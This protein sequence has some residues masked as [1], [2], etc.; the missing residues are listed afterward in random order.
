MNKEILAKG[1]KGFVF[2]LIP[3]VLIT[4]KQHGCEVDDWK[5]LGA[6]LGF[7]LIP[8]IGHAAWYYIYPPKT[9]KIK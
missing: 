6:D 4:L 7:A 5:A 1:I 9:L 8:A 3:I 2:A